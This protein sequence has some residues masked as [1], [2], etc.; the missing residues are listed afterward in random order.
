MLPQERQKNSEIRS[1]MVIATMLLLVSAVV[2]IQIIKGSQFDGKSSE[3]NDNSNYC[4]PKSCSYDLKNCTLGT[5]F[6][7]E[8]NS[9]CVINLCECTADYADRIVK[10]TMICD[11]YC[12]GEAVCVKNKCV[13]KEE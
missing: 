9:D 5:V 12:P 2:I 7:C 3:C 11:R 8:R 4:D 10:N 13:L 1:M 6:R